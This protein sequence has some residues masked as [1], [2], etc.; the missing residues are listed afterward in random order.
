[1]GTSFKRVRVI[2]LLDFSLS[3]DSPP[4]PAHPPP[5]LSVLSSVMSSVFSPS[6]VSFGSG[7]PAEPKEGLLRRLINQSINQS[8]RQDKA[9]LHCNLR[10]RWKVASDLRI[11]AAISEPK[12]SSFCGISSDLAQSPRKSLA[13]AIVRFWCAKCSILVSYLWLCPLKA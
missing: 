6:S 1:M 8:I 12:T 10:V 5:L 3:L 4:S 9:M 13:I 11:R 7:L 2:R